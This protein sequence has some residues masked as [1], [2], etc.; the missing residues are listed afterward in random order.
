M[1]A[2]EADLHAARV[3][4]VDDLAANVTLL[5]RLLQ[6]E[7]YTAVHSTRDP[8]AVCALHREHDYDLILLDLAMPVMDGFAVMQQMRA[9]T[10]QDLLPVLVLTA[11][12]GHKLRALQGGARDFVAKPFDLLEVKTRIR[13]L[14]EVRL[15]QRRLQAHNERLE[16]TVLERTAELSA[17][18]AR[19]RCLTELASDWYWEQDAGGEFTTVSGPVMEMLGIELPTRPGDAGRML[20][21]GWEDDERQRLR[22]RIDAREPFLDLVFHRP[23]RDGSRREFRVSGQPMFD[24]ACRFVG[25]RGIGIEVL[26]GRR[27]S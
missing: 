6:Q 5:T 14:L 9:M 27:P 17:S 12:P 18:E 3:L 4:I 2:I 13:N 15:L 20:D 21:L 16:A 10:G 8:A 19:Y 22:Q 1:N 26:A 23:A 24:P 7:G 25:Y 11:Q